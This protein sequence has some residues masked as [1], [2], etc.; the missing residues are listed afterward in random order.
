LEARNHKPHYHV[1]AGLIWK[2]GKLLITR[3]PAGRHL[4]GFWEFP[5]GK[6]EGNE[7]LEGC[8]EREIKE[9]LGIDI[10]AESRF[11]SVQYEYE[12]KRITL[13]VFQCTDLKG[14]PAALEG[15]ETRWVLPKDLNR[16]DFPPPDFEVIDALQGIFDA[17]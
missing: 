3:R 8:L 4:A 6:Q 11:L 7:S 5:G 12:T 15:Q 14:Q 17:V 16:Y 10:R 1:T 2:D 13:H 9:E